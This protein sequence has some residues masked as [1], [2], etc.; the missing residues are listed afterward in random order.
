M[1]LQDSGFHIFLSSGNQRG[2]GKK[3]AD[4]LG[5]EFSLANSA[6]EK[7]QIWNSIDPAKSVAIGNARIDIGLFGKSRIS[8]LTL[9]SEGIHVGALQYADILI[10][11]ICDALDLFLEPDRLLATMK[12]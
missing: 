5:I 11:S 3:I 9:Q 6:L 12:A 4:E 7:S 1:K 10:P 2:N 8:I